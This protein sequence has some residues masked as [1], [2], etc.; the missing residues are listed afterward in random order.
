MVSHQAHSLLRMV[1]TD[2]II[3][4][5]VSSPWY[6]VGIHD[7]YRIR[8]RRSNLR[9]KLIELD[10]DQLGPGPTALHYPSYTR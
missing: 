6:F 3:I 1:Q 10:L 4:N 2:S 7:P 8:Q 9:N 5:A